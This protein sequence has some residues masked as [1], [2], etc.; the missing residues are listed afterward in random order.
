M[1]ARVGRVCQARQRRVVSSRRCRRARA[2][3]QQWH[4][5]ADS[6]VGVPALAGPT[7]NDGVQGTAS[8]A[9]PTMTNSGVGR[10]G[11]AVGRRDGPVG[12][13]YKEGRCVSPPSRTRT[14]PA[15]PG[16]LVV[17]AQG[18]MEPILP[19]FPSVRQRKIIMNK[20]NWK[21]TLVFAAALI[22]TTVLLDAEAWAGKPRTV[23][24][25]PPGEF[26]AKSST[27]SSSGMLPPGFRAIHGTRT[28][29]RDS[30]KLLMPDGTVACIPVRSRC[31]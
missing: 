8:L 23:D 24:P 28:I 27:R 10:E 29:W 6:A 22:G 17:R 19:V 31:S 20:M 2:H 5:V 12:T 26:T 25:P 18:I 9:H 13:R 11:Q 21:W 3:Q 16:R 1:V 30:R 15:A 14:G 7:M 4:R